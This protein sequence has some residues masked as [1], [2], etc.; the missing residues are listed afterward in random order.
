MIIRQTPNE[1]IV[2]VLSLAHTTVVT[3]P[4]SNSPEQ[5]RDAHY[6]EASGATSH[7]DYLVVPGSSLPV[8]IHSQTPADALDISEWPVVRRKP[9]VNSVVLA[10]FSNS[11]VR[12]SNWR[13]D[14]RTTVGGTVKLPVEAAE[15]DS[16]FEY[17]YLAVKAIADAMVNNS[18]FDTSGNRAQASA[19]PHEFLTGHVWNGGWGV[20]GSNP[21]GTVGGRRF[22]AITPRHLY[23]CGHYQYYAGETLYWK[24]VNNNIISRQVVRVINL[25]TEM[26]AAGVPGW[27][28]SIALLDSD[29]PESIHI[30]PIAHELGRGIVASDETTATFCPQVF[31]FALLNNDGHLNAFAS[32]SLADE[33]RTP[34]NASTYQGIA[35]NGLR[36]IGV[37]GASAYAC[38]EME[39]TW[40]GSSGS[41]FYHALRGGDSGSPCIVPVQ[42]GWGF[43][44]VISGVMAEPSLMNELIALIDSRHGISTGHTVTEA[45]NPVE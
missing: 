6:T 8:E 45:T 15:P 19:I 32:A 16:Y 12:S 43:S 2:P 37:I 3:V 14:M 20:P 25:F 29:L 22:M 26:P 5:H 34:Y 13:F 42:G 1:E 39:P 27:D 21:S 23:G 38:S 9:G 30:L 31:G 7:R 4:G 44:G 35:F 41:K 10:S 40:D 17:S 36:T 24:D 28:S 11:R 33:V 18:M